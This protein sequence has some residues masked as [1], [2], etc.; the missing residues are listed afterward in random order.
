MIRSAPTDSNDHLAG[1]LA[2]RVQLDRL[3]KTPN[4]TLRFL[5]LLFIA[6]QANATEPT[7]RPRAGLDMDYGPFL[8]YSLLA[9]GAPARH[10]T[11]KPTTIPHPLPWQPTELLAHRGITAK[12]PHNAAI[13]F[14]AD[15]MRYAA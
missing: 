9:P 7:T 14:D 11:T 5:C 1:S 6:I 13:C 15:Q 8:A 12:L 3:E 2:S 4:S 10:P